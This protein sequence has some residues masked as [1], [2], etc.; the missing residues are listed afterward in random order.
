MNKPLSLALAACVTLTGCQAFKKSETWDKITHSRIDTMN[1]ADPGKAY[2][3]ELSR[4]LKTSR[5]EHKVVNYQYHYRNSAREEAVGHGTA[6][7]YRDDV[8][9]EHPWWLKDEKSGRPVWLPNGETSQQIAF[10]IRRNAE[11]VDT[12]DGKQTVAAERPAAVTRIARMVSP[13]PRRAIARTPAP[14]RTPDPTRVLPA[15]PDYDVMTQF[16]LLHGSTFDPAS[17]VDREKMAS[18]RGSTGNVSA[19][20]F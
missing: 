11:I 13:E 18:M 8:H 4:K 20:A 12:D 7:I 15:A 19:R 5:I 2:A 6:V 9:P 1:A 3:D 14:A 17:P 10:Y 16:R